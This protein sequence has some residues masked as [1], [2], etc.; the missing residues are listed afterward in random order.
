[1]LESRLLVEGRRTQ[2]MLRSSLWVKGEGGEGMGMW[3]GKEK[4]LEGRKGERGAERG[5]KERIGGEGRGRKREGKVERRSKGRREGKGKEE[6]GK[7][8]EGRRGERR[9]SRYFPPGVGRE[10][11]R[12]F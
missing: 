1:M 4:E 7:G 9:R 2:Y 6:R 12:C 10:H 11:R 8:K 5:G 3:M